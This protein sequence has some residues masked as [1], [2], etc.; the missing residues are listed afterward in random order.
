MISGKSDMLRNKKLAK[1]KHSVSDRELLGPQSETCDAKG[2]QYNSAWI[3]EIQNSRQRLA[4]KKP[5]K[6]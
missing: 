3:T 4:S 5:W 1:P 2:T 6:K